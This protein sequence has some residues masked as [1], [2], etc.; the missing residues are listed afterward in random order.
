M[1]WTP[2]PEEVRALAMAYGYVEDEL[3]D[4]PS[5]R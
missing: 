2:M 5:S 4:P 3:V 1:D